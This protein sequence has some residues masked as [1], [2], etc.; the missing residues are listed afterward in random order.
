M[1][2]HN[3]KCTCCHKNISANSDLPRGV[4]YGNNINAILITMMNEA[5]TPLNKIVSLISGMT[6]NEINMSESYLKKIE[7]KIF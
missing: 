6:K 2:R 7:K 3:Y 4:S 5:N 1:S